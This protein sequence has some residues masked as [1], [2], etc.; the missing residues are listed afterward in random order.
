MSK[1][2]NTLLLFKNF[3]KL[4]SDNYYLSVVPVSNEI[5]NKFKIK[6]IDFV[7]PQKNEILENYNYCDR[8]YKKLLKK[9][10]KLFNEIHNVNFN[11]REIE[12]IIGYW[13]KNYIYLSFKIFK[14]LEFVF[15]KEQIDNVLT[16]EHTSFNF[17]KENTLEFAGAHA[18]DLK[19]YY[20]FFSGALYI[21]HVY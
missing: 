4:S 14:Q 11:E 10:L 18:L 1:N 7:L 3:S 17:V 12:I 6:E 21:C 15:E 2:N 13:L 19:W 16:T 20:C 5:K 9:I 8:I